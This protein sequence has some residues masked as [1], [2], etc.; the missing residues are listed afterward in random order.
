M[1]ADASC[2]CNLKRSSWKDHEDRWSAEAPDV[3]NDGCV[4]LVYSALRDLLIV[5][6]RYLHPHTPSHVMLL[7][8]NDRNQDEARLATMSLELNGKV[9]VIGANPCE[10]KCCDPAD[11]R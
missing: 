1:A 2:H 5:P 3:E 9:S 6:Q 7:Q 11:E 8:P 4:R 10:V